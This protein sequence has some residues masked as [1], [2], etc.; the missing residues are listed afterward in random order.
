MS[1]FDD[2]MFN[3]DEYADD[4]QN[5]PQQQEEEN[6]EDAPKD[7]TTELLKI[8]GIEDS[9]KIKFEDETGATIERAWD[10]LSDNE[11]LNI[12]AG[13]PSPEVD[14]DQQ[15]DEDEI[16]L[17]NAIRNSG[18]NVQQYMNNIAPVQ[19][20]Q[21]YNQENLSDDELYALNILQTVGSDN[22]TDE[23]LEQAIA[24]AKENEDLYT[25]TVAG[26]RQQYQQLQKDEQ[27]RLEQE[28]YA[29]QQEQYNAFANVV[30][31]NIQ[32]FS[33]FAGQEIELDNDEKQQLRD[34][35]LNIDEKTG[36]SSLGKDLQNPETLVRAAFWILNEDKIMNE[37]AKQ[38]QDAYKRGYNAGKVASKATFVKKPQSK[39]LEKNFD[40]WDYI[41]NK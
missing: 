22:I 5:S 3:E 36:L 23:E 18:M 34:Y 30:D 32:N 39:P 9:S 37:L 19:A 14:E 29:K 28:Q 12:L 24:R 33:N 26:L 40:D 4:T 8:R 10:D 1:N 16:Q 25:R 17:I 11:K 13:E 2:D 7:L 20:P 35:M 41:I 6:Q 31:D 15:L 38:A 21:A 27:S